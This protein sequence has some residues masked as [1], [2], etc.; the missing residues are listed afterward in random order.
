ML[1]TLAVSFA[2]L[3][4][5]TAANVPSNV[6]FYKDV[7]PILQNRCQECHRPGEIAPMSFL[8]YSDTRPWSKAI[9]EAVLVRK[10]PPWF[11]APNYGHFANDRSLS[12]QE[13]DTLANWAE[14]GAIEGDGK[15]GPPTHVWPQG[16]NI[17]TPDAVLEMPQAFPIPASGAVEY[18]YV[19][20]PTRFSEDKCV[21]QVEVR[22]SD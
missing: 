8:T 2:G 4:A 14:A 6:T 11:A 5:A 17:G 21:Q 3:L 10:M 19:I 7:L 20:L 18:Q 16:W 15:D 22:P 13:M 9:R 12:K 1:R